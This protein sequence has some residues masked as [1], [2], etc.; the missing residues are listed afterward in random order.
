MRK[1]II[2]AVEKY[3]QYR[4]KNSLKFDFKDHVIYPEA[5]KEKKYLLYLHIPFCKVFC[6]YCSFHKYIFEENRAREYFA[7]LRKEIKIAYELGFD[8]SSIYIG[9][10]TPTIL[11][12]E[13]AKTID[14]CRKLWDIKEVSCEADP[15]ISDELIELLKSR[16]DR[17]SV[18]VQSLDAKRLNQTKRCEKFGTPYEQMKNIEKLI[19]NFKIVNC[20]LI[21]NFP[22]QTKEELRKDIRKLKSLSPHQISIYPLMYS[23][24]VKRIWEQ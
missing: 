16:V 10:G 6:P 19:A 5:Q 24:L 9:G 15:D 22:N 14:L 11:R 7:T 3:A 17:L 4:I 8:F 20:D 18:G 13:L 1:L 23:P 2:N 21:F 12:D